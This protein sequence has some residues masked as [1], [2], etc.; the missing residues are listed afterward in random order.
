MYTHTRT[1]AHTHTHA[2]TYAHLQTR[3]HVTGKAYHV[4]IV[5]RDER[6]GKDRA[7]AK[8]QRLAKMREEEAEATGKDEL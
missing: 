6:V 3:T 1:H 2:H 5:E 7:E 4:Q 8:A